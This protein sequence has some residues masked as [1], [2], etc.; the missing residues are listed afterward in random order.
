MGRETE[1]NTY[2]KQDHEIEILT[3]GNVR[4]TGMINV[5]GRSISTY[6]QGSEPD[7]IMYG[8]KPDDAESADTLIVSKDHILWVNSG[9]SPDEARAGRWQKLIFRMINGRVVTGEVNMTGYDRVSDYL[10]N[11]D[12]R[13]YEV[14]SAQTDEGSSGLLYVSRKA[15][16]WKEPA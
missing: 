12:E 6:L 16:V 4:V 8:C 3:T 7:I 14:Y 15:T 11:F 2:P 1:M 9:E 5:L 13:F 10:Q